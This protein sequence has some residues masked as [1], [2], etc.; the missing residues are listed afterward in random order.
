VSNSCCEYV[1]ARAQ[2]WLVE[3]APLQEGNPILLT[4]GFFETHRPWSRERYAPAPLDD[5]EVPEYLPDIPEVDGDINGATGAAGKPRLTSTHAHS[6][7][8]PRSMR[9]CDGHPT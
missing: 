2:Q 9:R 6:H 8:H 1:V 5:V 3:S 4:A 7:S